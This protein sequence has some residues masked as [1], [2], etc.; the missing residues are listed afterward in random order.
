MYEFIKEYWWIIAVFAGILFIL[1]GCSMLQPPQPP[2]PAEQSYD[3]ILK[4]VAASHDW[5]VTLS[6]VGV[7]ISV[8][9]TINGTKFG[10]PAAIGSLTSLGMALSVVRY[11]EWIALLAL[12]GAIGAFVWAVAIKNRAL[13]ELIFDVDSKVQSTTTKKIVNK[14]CKKRKEA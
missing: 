10:I 7:A 3:A 12:V 4:T 5:L 1:S 14:T 2:Q 8:A 11:A 6:I 9:A 13:R